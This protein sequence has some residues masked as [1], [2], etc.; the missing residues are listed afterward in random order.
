MD[1]TASSRKRRQ[2]RKSASTSRNPCTPKKKQKRLDAIHDRPSSPPSSPTTNIALDPPPR[3]SSRVRRPPA[4]LESSPDL[5]KFIFQNSSASPSPISRGRKIDKS[6]GGNKNI[7]KRGASSLVRKTITFV[8]ESRGGK[9]GSRLRSRTE[10]GMY[11]ASESEPASMKGKSLV[12]SDENGTI[13][14]ENGKE[15]ALLEEKMEV[16]ASQTRKGGN[17]KRKQKK[18]P[19]KY[20][21]TLVRS[22]ENESFKKIHEEEEFENNGRNEKQ[23]EFVEKMV[24]DENLYIATERK[25]DEIVVQINN[26][27]CHTERT[28]GHEEGND[29][30]EVPV[31]EDRGKYD[32]MGNDSEIQQQKE[33]EKCNDSNRNASHDSNGGKIEVKSSCDLDCSDLRNGTDSSPLQPY[34]VNSKTNAAT[35]EPNLNVNGSDIPVKPQSIESRR[36]GLCGRGSDGKPPKRLVR[37]CADSENEVY[38]ASSASEEPDYNL[39][40]GFGDEPD[41]LGHLLGPLRDRLGIIRIWVHQHCAVWSPEVWLLIIHLFF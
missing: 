17:R 34:A 38:N 28:T 29:M 26:K 35:V 21:D 19:V 23:T 16:D 2:K 7:V 32:I 5:S 24:Q 15:D 37:E 31:D 12:A 14:N 8:E 25:G 41:W 20:L 4:T 39:W 27:E 18:K 40:D 1:T 9:W 33:P 11:V 36:C 10:R 13:Q 3:R 30:V 6:N 22:G